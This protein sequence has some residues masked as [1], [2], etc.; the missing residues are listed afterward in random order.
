MVFIQSTVRGA[1][2]LHTHIQ[3]LSFSFLLFL[4][5]R[6]KI[7]INQ[8]NEK[9]QQQRKE[10]KKKQ[11]ENQMNAQYNFA[12]VITN[13][14]IV[15]IPCCCYYYHKCVLHCS[16]AVVKI[17][18]CEKMMNC[19]H[20]NRWWWTIC[21]YFGLLKFDLLQIIFGFG[22]MKNTHTY[23]QI[24]HIFYQFEIIDE[25]YMVSGAGLLW[26]MNTYT[27][28]IINKIENLFMKIYWIY[29]WLNWRSFFIHFAKIIGISC[30][31]KSIK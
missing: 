1:H 5:C 25:S 2:I 17:L 18:N 13:K 21:N 7:E 29:F 8:R 3:F 28:A 16:V 31:S 15:I 27:G 11:Y 30:C 12:M 26:S 4:L 14:I 24:S 22:K 10:R 20:K 23:T 9:L 19:N 6:H